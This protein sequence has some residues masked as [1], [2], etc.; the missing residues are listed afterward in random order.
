MSDGYR[1]AL[2]GLR[3]VAVAAVILYHLG[4]ALLSAGQPAAAHAR[5]ARVLSLDP[6]F[7]TAREIRTVLVRR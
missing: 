6:S 7:P 1:P 3:A 5:F 2:D 4:A